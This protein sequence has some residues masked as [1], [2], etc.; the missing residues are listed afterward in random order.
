MDTKTKWALGAHHGLFHLI[1]L[2]FFAQLPAA[3]SHMFAYLHSATDSKESSEGLWS[4]SALHPP[5]SPHYHHHHHHTHRIFLPWYFHLSSGTFLNSV[6]YCL[7]VLWPENSFR[8]LA[9]AI[10][11]LVLCSFS[12]GLLSYAASY[13]TFKNHLFIYVI[14]S[15]HLS[16]KV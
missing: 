2:E 15:L 9:R 4:M 10:V 7:P 14:I 12:Q 1:L 3:F 6:C 11:G 16:R 13:I 5:H 8:Q